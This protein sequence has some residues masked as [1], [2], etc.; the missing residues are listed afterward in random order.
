MSYVGANVSSKG[1][2]VG[3]KDNV[4]ETACIIDKSGPEKPAYSLMREL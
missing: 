2:L 1:F 3:I 4:T